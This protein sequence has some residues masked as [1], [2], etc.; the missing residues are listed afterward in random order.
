SGECP[1]AL[2]SKAAGPPKAQVSA[3]KRSGKR[4]VGTRASHPEGES[5]ARSG[6]WRAVNRDGSPTE[7]VRR[8]HRV[9]VRLI[10]QV[11]GQRGGRGVSARAG[12]RLPP[13]FMR[14]WERL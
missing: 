6:L 14:R 2:V 5:N 7:G 8:T 11:T 12:A 10:S 9:A 13:F 1:Q 3:R 4:T